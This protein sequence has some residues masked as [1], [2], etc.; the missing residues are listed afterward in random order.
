MVYIL[1]HRG[2]TYDH[3]DNTIQSLD[4][5]NN[6][7]QNYS[8]L[9]VELDV[10]L[11]KDEKVICLHDNNINGILTTE[12]L[13]DNMKIVPL[14]DDVIKLLKKYKIIINIE[15]KNHFEKNNK[16]LVKKVLEIIE[17][18][19][20]IKKCL[21]TSFNHEIID[22]ISKKFNKGYLFEKVPE[23]SFKGQILIFGSNIPFDK[24][25]HLKE[26][27]IIGWYPFTEEDQPKNIHN[28]DIIIT[29]DIKNAID[30]AYN[31]EL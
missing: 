7:L 25:E 3:K 20:V 6:Y 11:S 16:I 23:K 17:D 12:I 28:Y 27:N 13:Y 9:G 26:K 30:L 21:I 22:N 2:V 10:T 24:I 18:H 14:L 5:I 1:A 15:I 29:D 8:E 31:F 19:K 4:A